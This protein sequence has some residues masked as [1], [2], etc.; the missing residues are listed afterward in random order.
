MG[1]TILVVDDERDIVE[2]LQYNLNR[3]GYSVLVAGDGLEALRLA[4]TIPDLILLDVMMPQMDGHEVIKRLKQNPVTRTISVVFLTAKGMESDEVHGL[5]LGAD[6]YVVKPI[7]ISRLLARIKSVLRR[8]EAE[9]QSG[10]LE[11]TL[12]I[13]ELEIDVRQYLI[14]LEGKEAHLPKKEFETL[15]FL[16]RNRGNVVSRDEMLT[17][18]WGEDVVVIDRTIDVH[19]RKIREKLGRH[20]EL[21]ETVKGVGYRLR[22]RS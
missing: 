8:K 3:A 10:T 13:G 16:A 2:L 4:N 17:S 6:D 14:R 12:T 11:D 1:K 15:L 9:R 22:M 20:A 19:I 21:L 5:E 18:V 7:A